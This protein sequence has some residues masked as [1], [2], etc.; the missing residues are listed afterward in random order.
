MLMMWEDRPELSAEVR[1]GGTHRTGSFVIRDLKRLVAR[2]N[3]GTALYWIL[4]LAISRAMSCILMGMI[5][6]RIDVLGTACT[7]CTGMSMANHNR[8][9]G[10]E[11]VWRTKPL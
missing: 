10:I 4:A 9:I 1:E 6:G 5:L 3:M 11:T 7:I 8:G 2:M